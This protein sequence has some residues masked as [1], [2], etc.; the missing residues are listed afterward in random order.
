MD[1]SEVPAQQS[2]TS[3]VTTCWSPSQ[4]VRVWKAAT[5]FYMQSTRGLTSWL[6]F[7]FVLFLS[8]CRWKEALAVNTTVRQP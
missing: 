8:P 2:L 7:I 6:F 3:P 1:E 5:A 4:V